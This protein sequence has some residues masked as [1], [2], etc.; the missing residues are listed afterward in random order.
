[1][2]DKKTLLEKLDDLRVKFHN[3]L[4]SMEDFSASFDNFINEHSKTV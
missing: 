2:D 1:M 3:N 4:I